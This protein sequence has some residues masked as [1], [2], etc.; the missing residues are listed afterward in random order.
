MSNFTRKWMHKHDIR[1]GFKPSISSETHTII[2]SAV[3]YRSDID[4]Y[5]KVHLIGDSKFS[6]VEKHL[7]VCTFTG[8]VHFNNTVSITSTVTYSSLVTMVN[9]KHTGTEDHYGTVNFNGDVV[10]GSSVTGLTKEMVDLGNVDNTSDLA[11]PMSTATQSYVDS[12]ITNLIDTS[13]DALDTLNEL[14]AALND[15]ANF[16]STI[17][18]Q[19]ALKANLASP[20]FTGTVGGITKLMV[21]LGKV[22]NTSDADKPVSTYQQDALDLKVNLADPTFNTT[23]PTSQTAGTSYFDTSTN[24]LYIYNGTAWKS[25]VLS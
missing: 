2:R 22:D 20:T 16:G 12:K 3:K 21:G 8:P 14:A 4:Y 15:D 5:G 17:T 19:L 13:P 1:T 7:G 6:G 18:N 9:S 24:T 23:V 10:F 25:V 11:K